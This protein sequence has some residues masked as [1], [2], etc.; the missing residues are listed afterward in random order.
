MNL[1]RIKHGLGAVDLLEVPRDLQNRRLG[2]IEVQAGVGLEV[3]H[4]TEEQGRGHRSISDNFGHYLRA[5]ARVNV[6][7]ELSRSG[8]PCRERAGRF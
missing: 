8:K 2:P 7:L 6:N 4:P 1:G 5:R 3:H